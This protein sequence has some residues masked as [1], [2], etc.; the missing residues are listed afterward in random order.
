[1]LFRL[2]KAENR[3]SWGCYA[4]YSRMGK[5]SLKTSQVDYKLPRQHSFVPSFICCIVEYTF[6]N[7][8]SNHHS[9]VLRSR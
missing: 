4:L 2:L 9:L 8:V 6:S 5:A 1:M 3:V 7:I